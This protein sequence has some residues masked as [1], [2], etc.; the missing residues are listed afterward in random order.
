MKT[1]TIAIISHSGDIDGIASAFLLKE[2]FKVQLKNIFFVNYGEEDL[3]YVEKEIRKLAKKGKLSVLISDLSADGR[4]METFSRILEIANRSGGNLS[5]FDHHPWG[6]DAIRK[7]ASRCKIAIVGENS[8]FCATEIVYRKF[9]KEDAFLDMLAE[10]VHYSDF[11]I[12]PDDE[13][14]RKIVGYYALGITYY[15]TASSRSVVDSKMRSIIATLEKKRLYDK[16]IADAARTFEKV[17]SK[18]IK[19]MSRKLYLIG[20]ELAVGFST[21]IQSTQ[22]CASIIE[23]SGRD[24]GVYINIRNGK[25]HIRSVKSNTS[26]LARSLGGN[27]H[28]HASG[29]K[30]DLKEYN[31]FRSESDKK[32]VVELIIEKSRKVL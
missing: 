16:K 17:N 21:D 18:R 10:M 22:A 27:G 14:T 30:L 7:I 9:F 13:G 28:P 20:S 26:M 19:R 15:N 5:W 8:K 12:R 3:A 25:G 29:F 31:N 6:V 23:A 1:E 24:V 11:N 2:A 4:S 32:R